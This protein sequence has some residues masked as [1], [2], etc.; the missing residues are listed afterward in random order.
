MPS[1]LGQEETSWVSAVVTKRLGTRMFNVRV[2]L[3]GPICSRHLY[4]LQYRN[5]TDDDK[6]S[7][8]VPSFQN[9]SPKV[10]NET[11]SEEE[12]ASS[13]LQS[14]AAPSSQRP[15][16]EE[17]FRQNPRRSTRKRRPSVYSVS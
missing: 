15:V 13:P 14:E 17:Y 5:A 16:P 4:Q 6:D 8:D 11:P 10:A 2:V 9:A 3:N 7:A 12:E 1:T